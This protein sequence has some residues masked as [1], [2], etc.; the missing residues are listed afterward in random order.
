MTS[1]SHSGSGEIERRGKNVLCTYFPP[2]KQT[3]NP[4]PLYYRM[5]T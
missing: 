5:I 4:N 1:K 2:N 3:K